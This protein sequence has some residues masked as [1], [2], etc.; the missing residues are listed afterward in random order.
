MVAPFSSVLEQTVVSPVHLE[1]Y[2][3]SPSVLTRTAIN[4]RVAALA[5]DTDRWQSL[6]H[7][8]TDER[9][10]AQLESNPYYDAW[11]LSWTPG[12]TTELH[13]HGGSSGAFTVLTGSLREVVLA[14]G[15]PRHVDRPAG[16]TVTFGSK[17]IHDVGHAGHGPA[18][19]L[20]VYSPPLSTM[21]YYAIDRGE[22]L[23]TRTEATET[24]ERGWPRHPALATLTAVS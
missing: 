16:S 23:R 4:Q 2:L 13:D 14:A 20:H 8:S 11:L 5:A 24:P 17:Y 7:Y 9:W 18:A 1:P 10:Y 12:Q 15:L 19:S 3:L 21:N 22:V 6:L